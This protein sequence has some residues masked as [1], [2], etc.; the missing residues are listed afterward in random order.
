MISLCHVASYNITW[1]AKN[2]NLPHTIVI[3]LATCFICTQ[4]WNIAMLYIMLCC[5][6]LI[7]LKY[8][9]Q[10][11]MLM[12]KHAPHFVMFTNQLYHRG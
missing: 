8:Y 3:S 4:Q 5:S 12:R 7:L 11:Y 1:M 6:T 2:I 10:Y 9:S